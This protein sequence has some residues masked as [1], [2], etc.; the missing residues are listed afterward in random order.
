MDAKLF[1]K[2]KFTF[3]IIIFFLIVFVLLFQVK[4]LFFPD[5]GKANYGNRLDGLVQIKD[6]QLTTLKDNIKTEARV[7][8]VEASTSGRILNVIIT[9]EKDV[10]LNDAKVIGEKASA[11]LTEEILASYDIQ[12]FVKKD[13]EEEN[14]FPII[15]YKSNT[16]NTYSWIKDRDKKI[17][18]TEEG[19]E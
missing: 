4:G 5:G 12:V 13:E 3:F 14:N 8:N 10:S 17:I 9:V 7:K 11:T 18:E 15:G 1:K 16:D 2:N 6:D 19:E